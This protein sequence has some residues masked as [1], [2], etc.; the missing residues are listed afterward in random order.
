MLGGALADFARRD[1]QQL[2]G[3]SER[4]GQRCRQGVIGVADD[5]AARRQIGDLGRVANGGDDG[6][7]GLRLQQFLAKNF[8][9]TVSP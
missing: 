3:A 1:Q 5:D 4:R 2:V 9:T 6:R 7:R 8:A